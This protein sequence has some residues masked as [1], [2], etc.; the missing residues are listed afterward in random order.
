MYSIYKIFKICVLTPCRFLSEG[1]ERFFIGCVWN[2]RVNFPKV[3]PNVL[4]FGILAHFDLNQIS[5]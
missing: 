5:S 3:I 2:L 4:K 1:P